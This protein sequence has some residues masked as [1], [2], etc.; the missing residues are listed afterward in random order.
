MDSETVLAPDKVHELRLL[1]HIE[2]NPD[3]TQA[4]LAVQLGVAVG[5][6]NWYLKRLIG[7]GYIKVTHLQRRRL[8]YLITPQGISEKTRLALKYV[9]VS[10]FMYRLAR[11]QAKTLLAQVRQAGYDRVRIEGDGDL[12]DVCRLTCLE[13]SVRV[14]RSGPGDH[15][16]ALKVSGTS[17]TLEMP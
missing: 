13:Q 17:V 10:M 5:T 16:P 8:R 6:V 3:A 9:Q 15:I 12:A 14:G 1:E 7:K 4:D 11:Q 2:R